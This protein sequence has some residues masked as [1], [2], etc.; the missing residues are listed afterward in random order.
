MSATTIASTAAVS[1]TGWQAGFLDVLPAVKTHAMIR[2]RRLTP[3][4]REDAV[5]ETI[6]AACVAYQ[7]LAAQGR[8][9]VLSPGSLATFS[10]LRVTDGRH[11]GGR[12]DAARD[13]LSP[14]AQRRHDFRAT[15]YEVLDE[16][17]G[18][19]REEAIAGRRYPVPDAVAFRLDFARWLGTLSRRDRRVVAA[20]GRGERT[21]DVA[22][23]LGISEARVSQLR[24]KYERQW[25]LFQGESSLEG[26][27]AA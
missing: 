16:E 4:R 15:S 1:T 10:V 12:R 25:A 7:L 27:V 13:A 21:M 3:E 9:H 5:Q 19:W 18:E 24:R 2:F 6:A 20:L 23:R 26:S 17:M 8:L 22:A 14:R 11:V